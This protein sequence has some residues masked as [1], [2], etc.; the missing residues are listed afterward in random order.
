[1]NRDTNSLDLW[2]T[3]ILQIYIQ[4]GVA[5]QKI[6]G[7]HPDS[8]GGA[9][10]SI[11]VKKG[12]NKTKLETV[13]QNISLDRD[14]PYQRIMIKPTAVHGCNCGW[15]H[16]HFNSVR[17]SSFGWFEVFPNVQ[18]NYKSEPY[19]EKYSKTKR[20]DWYYRYDL[21][22]AWN[23][24]IVVPYVDKQLAANSLNFQSWKLR[25]FSFFFI[26]SWDF[27]IGYQLRRTLAQDV[28]NPFRE[29]PPPRKS[30]HFGLINNLLHS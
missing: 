22:K 9:N 18:H 25:K 6:F 2:K 17:N 1:M 21:H 24:T 15:Y 20:F 4:A 28:F 23:C 5:Q 27:R 3:E 10:E 13:T 12:Q 14:V 19:R 11:F 16:D 7:V 26:G 8:G 30:D 29:Y